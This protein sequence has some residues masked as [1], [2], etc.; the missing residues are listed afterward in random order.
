MV[1][2]SGKYLSI[3]IGKYLIETHKQQYNKIGRSVNTNNRVPA[4][5]GFSAST[6]IT[7]PVYSLYIYIG[8]KH[9]FYI[10]YFCKTDLASILG[11]SNSH[12][13]DDT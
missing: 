11:A 7:S 3:F 4:A 12:A 9:N 10:G 1:K 8:N 6:G 2:N 5:V 13:I